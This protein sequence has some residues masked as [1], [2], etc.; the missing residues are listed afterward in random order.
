MAVMS[1]AF[2]LVNP[3]ADGGR[4]GSVVDAMR[5]WL[6]SNAPDAALVES[7]SI[8]RSRAMLQCLPEGTRVVLIGGDGTLHHML[9]VL[10]AQRFTLG[11]VPLGGGNDTARALGLHGMDWPNALAHALDGPVSA[12]DTG[13]LVSA[14]RRVPFASSLAVGFDAAVGRR[15]EEAPRWLRGLPRFL[16]ATFA[17][18]MS[19]HN[20]P[21][22]V[23]VDGEL[24]HQ[25]RAL[26]AST[27]NT[28][29]YGC[30]M[31]AVPRASVVDG[32]LNLLVAG[33]F[34]RF[35]TLLMLPRLL[36]GAHLGHARIGC[37]AFKRVH[38]EARADVPIAADG[39]PL[40]TER[41]FEVKVRRGSLRVVRG[42][43]EG[44]K[45]AALRRPSSEGIK[46]SGGATFP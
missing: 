38:I 37:V 28:P 15:A 29:T 13:E 33:R 34:G 31:L 30:G 24:R 9:P 10:L 41:D 18:L 19:F 21:M 26:L 11:L 27:L 39:E 17:E 8:A 42:P 1:A 25:G 3:N 5:A 4:A 20:W 16:W 35:A 7:D 6:A 14:R 45:D 2:V 44:P 40:S 36:R 12:M 32:R 22:K 23:T 46:E 43:S